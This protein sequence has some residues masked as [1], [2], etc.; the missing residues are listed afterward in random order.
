MRAR[1]DVITGI[2]QRTDNVVRTK[3]EEC[4]P[5]AKKGMR[6][7]SIVFNV[8]ERVGASTWS[9]AAGS[10]VLTSLFRKIVDVFRFTHFPDVVRSVTE[11]RIK[12]IE[13]AFSKHE[14]QARHPMVKVDILDVFSDR[15][16]FDL[17]F[18]KIGHRHHDHIGVHQHHE[19]NQRDGSDVVRNDARI[20]LFKSDR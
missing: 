6:I 16:A 4:C 20:V 17:K 5:F 10:L 2:E 12:V 18:F 3:F 1:D 7:F 8:A 9:Q 13:S 11:N 19:L 14:V 15:G